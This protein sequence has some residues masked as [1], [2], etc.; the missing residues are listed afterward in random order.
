MT[1]KN[2]AVDEPIERTSLVETTLKPLEKDK[3][4]GAATS[5][6]RIASYGILIILIFGVG[7]LAYFRITGKTGEAEGG[8]AAF[9]PIEQ[10][11]PEEPLTESK[12]S[13]EIVTREEKPEEPIQKSIPSLEKLESYRHYLFAVNSLTIKFL[14]DKPYEAELHQIAQTDL[15]GEIELIIQELKDYSTNYLGNRASEEEIVFPRTFRVMERF[16]VIKKEERN[17][18][19]KEALKARISK[20]L[21]V[22]TDYFYSAK[23][24]QKFIDEIEK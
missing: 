22:L 16:I 21:P 18:P 10:T 12:G 20:N 19:L 7:I 9:F 14:Q 11:H 4:E 15:P 13:G 23:F 6:K 8:G 2:K 24:G 1:R 5:T 3:S 17:T